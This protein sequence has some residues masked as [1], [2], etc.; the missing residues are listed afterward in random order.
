MTVM[1]NILKDYISK[2]SISD[3]GS[4]ELYRSAR[5]FDEDEVEILQE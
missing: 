5:I 4:R 3:R 1:E 2:T